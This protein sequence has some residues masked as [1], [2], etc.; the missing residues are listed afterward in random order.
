[1]SFQGAKINPKKFDKSQLKFYFILIPISL[2][3]VLPIV[4]IINQAFKPMEELFLFPPRFFVRQPTLDNF[5]MLFRVASFTSVPMTRYLFN[6]I[7][8][9]G[10]TVISNIV[11]TTLSGYA[12]SKKRFKLKDKLFAINQLALMFVG[13]AVVIP[14]YLVIVNMNLSDNMLSH[15]LPLLA[16]PVGL[17]LV[18]QFIDQVPDEIIE[19]ARIDGANEFQVLFRVVIPNII[20][21]LATV[22][23][24]TFQTSWNSIEASSLYIQDETLKTFAFYLSTLTNQLAP[25]QGAGM[26]AAAGLIL[27]LPNLIIFIILQ[28]NV[29]D[30][31]SHSGIK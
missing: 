3:M 19:A 29:M 14:R 24:L 9:T 25:V 13:V 31:M 12:L 1:M 15:I 22:G 30:T 28:S 17:F 8:V 11:I 23:I 27:L 10:V 21:A 16:V 18:K 4:Y 2:F 6:S 26:S 5:Q 20:P 7:I